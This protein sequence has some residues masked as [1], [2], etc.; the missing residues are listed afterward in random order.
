MLALFLAELWRDPPEYL[1]VAILLNR[2]A[3][4]EAA[5]AWMDFLKS[6]TAITI[7]QSYGYDT[8]N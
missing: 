1:G 2:G 4:N 5:R 3:S 8:A 7:I 6:D